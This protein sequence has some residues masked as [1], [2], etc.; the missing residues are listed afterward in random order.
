MSKSQLPAEPSKNGIKRTEDGQRAVKQVDLGVNIFLA[1]LG[2]AERSPAELGAAKCDA[3]IP[4]SA[5]WLISQ[6]K[7][8]SLSATKVKPVRSV[9]KNPEPQPPRVRNVVVRDPSRSPSARP[10]YQGKDKS[11]TNV[12][13]KGS[14]LT[15]SQH[16]STGLLVSKLNCLLHPQTSLAT[17][18]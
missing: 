3:C 15:Q 17:T 1:E 14:K 8:P 6:V 2:L 9:N 10:G 16:K 4:S 18:L 5:D 13:S 12:P 7:Q 11:S